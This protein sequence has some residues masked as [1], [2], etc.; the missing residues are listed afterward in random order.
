MRPWRGATAAT[1]DRAIGGRP[2][3]L[4]SHDG[5]SAWA[6][7]EALRRAG[8]DGSSADPPGGRLERDAQGEL[9]GVLRETATDL[10]EPIAER[11]RR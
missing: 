7:P 3:L 11:L 4:Y 2:A 6:S 8:L 5:H 10:V 1:L 9:S